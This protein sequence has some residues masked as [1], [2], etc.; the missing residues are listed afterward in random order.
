LVF[1]AGALLCERL[2]ERG[3]AVLN[4]AMGLLGRMQQEGRIE[5]I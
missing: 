2:R 4:E 1:I 3:L 5:G